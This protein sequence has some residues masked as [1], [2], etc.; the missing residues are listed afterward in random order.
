[1][2]L[3]PSRRLAKSRSL[4]LDLSENLHGSREVLI[5]HVRFRATL[6]LVHGTARQAANICLSDIL[7]RS[8]VNT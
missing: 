3:L 5:T 8:V 1:M 2:I 4:K 6:K 7:A